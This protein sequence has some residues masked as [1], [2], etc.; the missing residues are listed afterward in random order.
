MGFSNSE[1]EAS[2]GSSD[3]ITRGS[4][5]CIHDF[6]MSAYSARSSQSRL[7]ASHPSDDAFTEL[8]N[9]RERSGG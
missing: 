1:F 8:A 2:N 4:V 6:M 5:D 7:S 9:C 3:D